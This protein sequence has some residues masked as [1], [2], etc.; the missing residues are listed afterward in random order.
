MAEIPFNGN[1]NGVLGNLT[2]TTQIKLARF[3]KGSVVMP[4]RFPRSLKEFE[5]I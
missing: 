3:D 2:E 5:N 1:S 4:A